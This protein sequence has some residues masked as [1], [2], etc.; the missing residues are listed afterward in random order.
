MLSILAA[1]VPREP[2]I[3]GCRYHEGLQAVFVDGG[4]AGNV[5]PDRATITLNHRYAP[6]RSEQTALVADIRSL[7]PAEPKLGAHGG[8]PRLVQWPERVPRRGPL[9]RGRP[10]WE[11][12]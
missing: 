6:D 10:G 11:H 4:A 7:L 5:V 3:Q 2:E 12:Q 8:S 9:F 1:Y